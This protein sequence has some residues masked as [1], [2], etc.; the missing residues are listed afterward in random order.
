MSQL[1]LFDKQTE[2]QPV[3]SGSFDDIMSNLEKLNK[4]AE[5]SNELLRSMIEDIQKD[6]TDDERLMINNPKEYYKKQQENKEPEIIMAKELTTE[7]VETLKNCR[8]EGH[9]VKLPEAQLDR[10]VYLEVKNRLE[11]IGG[12]WKTGKISGFVFNEDPTELLEQIANGQQRNIKKEFQFFGTPDK[13]ADRLV[14]LAEIK[15]TDRVLEP[16]AGQGAIVRAINRVHPEMMVDCFE[17]M[18]LNQTFLKKIPTVNLKGDDFIRAEAHANYDVIIANP[19]FSKNQDI[20]HIYE[21]MNCVREGGR[22]VSLSSKHWQISNNTRE[23]E[24]RNELKKYNAQIIDIPAG[25]FKES[26]TNISTCI[27]VIDL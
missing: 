11:L 13:L 7:A 6:W 19:P 21:M 12:K 25:E 20:D 22:I 14:S 24:F 26:G 4:M 23:R 18:P 15:S 2:I 17:L 8:V 10:N 3:K 1:S 5:A 16:S 27:V 9:V